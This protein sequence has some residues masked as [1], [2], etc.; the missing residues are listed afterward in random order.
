MILESISIK[1]NT[2]STFAD[3]WDFKIICKS[4][5]KVKAILWVW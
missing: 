1:P 3:W 4:W 2:I 5:S